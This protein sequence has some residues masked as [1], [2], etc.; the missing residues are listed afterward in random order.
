MLKRD[1]KIF[2]GQKMYADHPTE[3]EDKARPERSI[4]DWVATLSEVTCDENGVV[5]F[6]KHTSMIDLPAE[7]RRTVES[8]QEGFEP[9]K[10]FID[11][12]KAAPCSDTQLNAIVCESIQQ[13]IMP[14][15]AANDILRAW[16]DNEAPKST[17]K[18]DWSGFGQR[19]SDGFYSDRNGWTAHGLWTDAVG[20]R[21]NPVGAGNVWSEN[22]ARYNRIVTA[23]L[24]LV[25]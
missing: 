17:A 12:L 14:G 4:R 21:S 22:Q 2:E 13:G 20:K 3:A 11:G 8:A 9:F 19:L 7:C 6:R 16:Y 10:R 24:A 1:Y 5:T 18:A 25:A 23:E 15:T